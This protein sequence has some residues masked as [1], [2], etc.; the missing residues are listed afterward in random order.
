M[1][2]QLRKLEDRVRQLE[3][4][5]QPPRYPALDQVS[6]ILA[7]ARLIRNTYASSA[8]GHE[9]MRELIR[10]LPKEGRDFIRYLA[11]L[12]EETQDQK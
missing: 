8:P 10:Y 1:T 12:V 9:K 6:D 7:A 2:D 5:T 11:K 3:Q 4:R